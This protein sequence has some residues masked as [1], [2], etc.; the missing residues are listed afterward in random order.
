[1]F[2]PAQRRCVT[3]MDVDGIVLGRQGAQYLTC[4]VIPKIIFGNSCKLYA[5][6]TE[7]HTH[8]LTCMSNFTLPNCLIPP[9]RNK[10]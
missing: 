3:G 4:T 9:L 5:K 6:E 2:V 7:E 1:M 10:L 8:S